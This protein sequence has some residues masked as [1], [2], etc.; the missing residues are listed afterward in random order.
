[1]MNILAASAGNHN[2]VFDIVDCSKHMTEG[3]KKVA[4][5]ICKQV[6][7]EMHELDPE[8]KLFDWIFFDGASYV[9]KAGSLF[10]KYFPHCTIS[11]Q[12]E[13]TISLFFGNVMALFPMK[14]MCGFAKKV[15]CCVCVCFILLHILRFSC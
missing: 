7:P 1:M 6:L 10:E 15:R 13:H 2:C 9:H 4:Y 11:I 5:F 8:K 3:G 14:K 12:V